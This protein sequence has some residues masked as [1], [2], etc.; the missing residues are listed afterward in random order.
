M[1]IG[2]ALKKNALNKKCASLDRIRQTVRRF[3]GME[4]ARITDPFLFF[5]VKFHKNAY[6]SENFKYFHKP[7]IVQETQWYSRLNPKYQS[8]LPMGSWSNRSLKRWHI[9]PKFCPHKSVILLWIKKL[10]QIH[11]NAYI[12]RNPQLIWTKIHRVIWI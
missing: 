3:S 10:H 8:I 2:S 4:C 9:W 1:W 7:L 12:I 5:F 6:I 11:I